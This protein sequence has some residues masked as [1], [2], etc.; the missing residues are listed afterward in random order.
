[1]E[2]IARAAKHVLNGFFRGDENVRAAPARTIA[3]LLNHLLGTSK[4]DPVT[5]AAADSTTAAHTTE[6]HQPEVTSAAHAPATTS[7]SLVE[8]HGNSKSKKKKARKLAQKQSHSTVPVAL[9]SVHDAAASREE[10]HAQLRDVLSKRFLYE[11]ILSQSP[12]ASRAAA[13]AAQE[14]LAAVLAEKGTAGDAGP[15]TKDDPPSSESADVQA[16]A[17]AMAKLAMASEHLVA[18]GTFVG[19]RISRLSLLRRVCQLCGIRIGNKSYDFD[20]AA[21]F[22]ADDITG[23][24]PRVKTSTGVQSQSEPAPMDGLAQLQ[25]AVHKY[26]EDGELQVAFELLQETLHRLQQVRRPFCSSLFYISKL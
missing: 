10:V 7:A 16:V 1:M 19:R 12:E 25:L 13:T 14:K 2:L 4:T 24:V 11:P 26:I 15:E 22:S 9:D 20:T 6:S 3:S 5:G 17:E 8:A 21:P 18:D 23:L